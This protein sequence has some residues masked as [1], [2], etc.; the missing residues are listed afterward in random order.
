M[1]ELGNHL[2]LLREQK[3]L[4]QSELGKLL[5]VGQQRISHLETGRNDLKFPFAI[6]LARALDVPLERLVPETDEQPA[7]EHSSVA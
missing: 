2:R 1:A 4:S 3:R 5:G 7:T 6:R